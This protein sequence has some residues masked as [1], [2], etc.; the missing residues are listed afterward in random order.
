MEISNEIMKLIQ[1]KV[2]CYKNKKYFKIFKDI[3]ISSAMKN[4]KLKYCKTDIKRNKNN[5]G[6]NALHNLVINKYENSSLWLI[7]MKNIF[8]N[9]EI[10]DYDLKNNNL[11]IKNESNIFNKDKKDEDCCYVF[12][13]NKKFQYEINNLV[14][15]YLSHLCEI[16]I[17]RL[18][19]IAKKEKTPLTNIVRIYL[20]L[21]SQHLGLLKTK[22]KSFDNE[23]SVSSKKIILKKIA[24]NDYNEKQLNSKNNNNN[25]NVTTTFN[26][27]ITK[28]KYISDLKTKLAK[29]NVNVKNQ[30]NKDSKNKN[31]DKNKNDSNSDSSVSYDDEEEK[32]K[33]NNFNN[34]II[35]EDFIKSLHKLNKKNKNATL[36]ILYSSSFTRLFIGETDTDSI[37]ER[38]LSNIDTKKEQKLEKNNKYYTLSG[39]YL[40][41]FLNRMSQDQKNSVPFMEKNMEALLNKFKKNQE[42]IDKFKRV[43]NDIEQLYH[44]DTITSKNEN[45]FQKNTNAKTITKIEMR[46]LPNNTIKTSYNTDVIDNTT[47]ANRSTNLLNSSNRKPHNREFLKTPEIKRCNLIKNNNEIKK[48]KRFNQSY[49]TRKMKDF[50]KI[51]KNKAIYGY[52]FNNRQYNNKNFLYKNDLKSIILKDNIKNSLLT[53]RDSNSMKKTKFQTIFNKKI[54]RNREDNISTVNTLGLNKNY[55]SRVELHY[56]NKHAS[57]LKNKIK[58]YLSKKDFYFY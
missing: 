5:L 12:P 21:C 49:N 16:K 37:R 42:L 41:M 6:N 57:T 36:K 33:E 7:I 48:I 11:I 31:I 25:E 22:K 23:S 56:N 30:S 55:T 53:E 40:K 3:L 38:Y 47:N 19:I 43:S 20:G 50:L 18:S 1:S 14:Y 17:Q 26:N 28:I 13:K 8:I 4:L 32:N 27:K 51:N 58:N 39:A 10:R 35:G 34:D 15:L 44:N 45:T 2:A 24:P 46:S 29:K 9:K 52:N 54:F